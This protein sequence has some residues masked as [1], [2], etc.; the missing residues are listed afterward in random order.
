MAI[1]LSVLIPSRNE[2]FLIRTV[3]DLLV[4]SGPETEIIA[5][6]DGW[7]C[8]IHT[9]GRVKVIRRNPSIGQRAATNEA[10]ELASG[11]YLMKVDAHCAFAPGFDRCMLDAF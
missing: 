3:Q 9:A 5:V 8:D 6:L 11:K 7:E 2:Q 4:H 10:A 1:E